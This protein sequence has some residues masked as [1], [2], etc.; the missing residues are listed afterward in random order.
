MHSGRE[1]NP[2]ASGK[3]MHS[4]QRPRAQSRGEREG[5]VIISIHPHRRMELERM[6]FHPNTDVRFVRQIIDGPDRVRGVKEICFVRDRKSSD[7]KKKTGKSLLE[8]VPA[9]FK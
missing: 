6:L 1:H 5:A 3:G 7:T 2:A 8:L 9:S 4:G